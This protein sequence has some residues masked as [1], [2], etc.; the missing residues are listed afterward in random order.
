MIITGSFP[1]MRC[2]V[3]TYTACLAEALGKLQ[4]TKIAILTG[5]HGAAGPDL[6]FEMFP[7]VYEWKLSALSNIIKTIRCWKPD[8]VHIQYPTQ[9]YGDT[10]FPWFLP[11]ILLLMNVAIVQTWHEDFPMARWHNLPNAIVP[12]GL[13][14]VRP[15][16]IASMP[17]WSRWLIKNK[18]FNFIP[19]TS[20]IPKIKLSDA[21][22][23]FLHQ[24]FTSLA[25]ALVVFF[26]F[27]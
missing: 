8:V 26:G 6:N 9:G 27:V 16:Y 24:R 3:G 2:G 21:E 19:N 17:A 13:I 23:S 20:P 22:R 4:D 11:I 7:I 14:V 1:P 18:Y 15:N 25:N 10:W 5:V 12:G